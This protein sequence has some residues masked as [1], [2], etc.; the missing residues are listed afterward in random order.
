MNERFV[1]H[2]IIIDQFQNSHIAQINKMKNVEFQYNFVQRQLI[3]AQI[4]LIFIEKEFRLE[5][6]KQ[7][8]KIFKLR[9]FKNEHRQRNDKYVE[10]IRNLR[11]DKNALKKKI[12]NLKIKQNDSIAFQDFEF[13]EN[14]RY[15][16]RFQNSFFAIDR[17]QNFE[18]VKFSKF[19]RSF[20]FFVRH[21]SRDNDIEQRSKIEIFAKFSNLRINDHKIFFYEKTKDIKNYYDDHVE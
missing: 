3:N 13:D 18:K 2:E 5:I 1:E 12:R 11:V 21:F 14:I 20:E 6:N 10:K 4:R 19:N 8:Q 7:K 9:Q 16:E 17:H 15:R